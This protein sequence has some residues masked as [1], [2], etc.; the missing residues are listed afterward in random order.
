MSDRPNSTLHHSLTNITVKVLADHPKPHSMDSPFV[1][2]EVAKHCVS[3]KSNTAPGLDNILPDFLR[4]SGPAFHSAL[5]FLFNQS[6]I[7]GEFPSAWK[8]SKAVPLYK[9]KGSKEDPS[10]YRLV[11]VTSI[12]SRTFERVVFDRLFTHLS[13][14]NFFHPSQ[15]G[16]RK[17]FATYDNIFLLQRSIYSAL[18]SRSHLPV[19]FLDIS[20]AFDAVWHNGLLSKMDTADIKGHA[21]NWLRSFLTNRS[22]RIVHQG[23]ISSP[24]CTSAGVPQGCVLSPLLFLIYINDLPGLLKDKATC[25]LYAD[26]IALHATHPGV[27]GHRHLQSALDVV[28]KWAVKWKIVF[29]KDKSQTLCF[30]NSHFH[31]P[32]PTFR[33]GT[34]VLQ[35]T[36]SYKYLGLIFQENGRWQEH[37]ESL[38]LRLHKSVFAVQRLVTAHSS[39]S[40][41]LLTQLLLAPLSQLEY[42]LAFWRPTIGQRDALLSILIRPL[43]HCLALPRYA[44]RHSILKEFGL[45]SIASLRLKCILQYSSRI[46]RM[47]TTHPCHQ[48][49]LSDIL[50]PARSSPSYCTRFVDESHQ[51]MRTLKCT[52]LSS[53]SHILS[54]V[55]QYDTSN[56]L[57]HK[58]GRPLKD[59]RHSYDGQAAYLSLPSL[60]LI[61]VLARLRMDLA[62][63]NHPLHKRNLAPSPSCTCNNTPE[64]RDHL[65][66]ACPIYHDARIQLRSC[67]TNPNGLNLHYILDTTSP[68]V[69]EFILEV[70]RIRHLL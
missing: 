68:A 48:A 64:T 15:A 8:S 50:S 5:C 40:P 41:L 6:W 32:I 42:G 4:H 39:P 18:R 28:D 59:C 44:H 13:K 14:R 27:S 43:R 1:V 10:N 58:Y 37:F 35:R 51:V 3:A 61:R 45:L 16:F 66:L 31:I 25:L 23:N 38:C 30:N 57:A 11:C 2:Q 19:A 29:S 36:Q 33:L 12:V 53:N 9:G 67:M 47:P 65:L 55:L 46:L 24:F 26:D 17:G 21:W 34:L 7:R 49:W 63:L 60:S 54:R 69:T 56:F 62:P 22:F 20:K 52:Q 70:N